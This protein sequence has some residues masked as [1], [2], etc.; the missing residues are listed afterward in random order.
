[1]PAEYHLNAFHRSMLDL[2]E[3]VKSTEDYSREKMA[4][5]ARKSGGVVVRSLDVTTPEEFEQNIRTQIKNLDS[6]FGSIIF[7]HPEAKEIGAHY[8]QA[9]AIASVLPFYYE[10]FHRAGGVSAQFSR[11]PYKRE[12]LWKLIEQGPKNESVDARI[13]RLYAATLEAQEKEAKSIA[14]E[15]EKMLR[16]DEAKKQL[17]KKFDELLETSQKMRDLVEKNQDVIS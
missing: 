17:L 1:M 16:R 12:D 8:A 14:N 11:A 4:A 5:A 3:T 2:H 6:F 7:Q 15:M 10:R 9:R 13:S